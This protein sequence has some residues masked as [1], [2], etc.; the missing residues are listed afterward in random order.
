MDESFQFWNRNVL[1]NKI[2]FE[3]SY[4]FNSYISSL[5]DYTMIKTEKENQEIARVSEITLYITSIMFWYVSY[6]GKK[7]VTSR[8]MLKRA[9]NSDR[10]Y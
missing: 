1:K 3:D 2:A 8:L 9:A 7:V 10:Q 4:F 6:Y 5:M